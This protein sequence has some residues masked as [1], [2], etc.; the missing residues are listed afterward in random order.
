MQ[1]PGSLI[2]KPG[3]EEPGFLFEFTFVNR[4][5][6]PVSQSWFN[7]RTPSVKTGGAFYSIVGWLPFTLFLSN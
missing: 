6:M 2:E 7:G 1:L 4:S 5:E 3:S